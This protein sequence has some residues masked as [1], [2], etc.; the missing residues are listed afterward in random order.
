MSNREVDKLTQELE[1]LRI[2]RERINSEEK[3]ALARLKSAVAGTNRHGDQEH[4]VPRTAKRSFTVGQRVY[5]TNRIGHVPLT[6]RT[7]LK[8]RAG[9]VQRV[10]KSRVYITTYNGNETWRIPGNVRQ[11][12]NEEHEEIVKQS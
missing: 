9:T 8:D 5:I 2:R 6:R 12:T 10:T 11:L 3:L 7:T 1:E 4:A